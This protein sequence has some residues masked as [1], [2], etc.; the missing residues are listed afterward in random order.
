MTAAAASTS[1]SG[2]SPNLPG[3]GLAPLLTLRTIAPLPL[4]CIPHGVPSDDTPISSFKLA[5]LRIL[6][7]QTVASSSTKPLTFSEELKEKTINGWRMEMLMLEL[8]QAGGQQGA[9]KPTA[10]SEDDGVGQAEEPVI[11]FE[12]LDEHDCSLLEEG[13]EIVVRLKPGHQ[14]KDLQ[15]PDLGTRHR[16]SAPAGSLT[17]AGTLSAPPPYSV[18]TPTEPSSHSSSV[19]AQ[20]N[21]NYHQ[22]SYQD[23]RQGF[24]VVTANNVSSGRARRAPA[25]AANVAVAAAGYGLGSAG[26]GGGLNMVSSVA[27]KP[28][29]G[30]RKV[31]ASNK[32]DRSA[33]AGAAQAPKPVH[34]RLASSSAVVKADPTPPTSPL[35]PSSPNPA[36]QASHDATGPRPASGSRR[37]SSSV[38]TQTQQQQNG[39]ASSSSVAFGTGKAAGQMSMPLTALVIGPGVQGAVGRNANSAATPIGSSG[40]AAIQGEDFGNANA[41]VGFTAASGEVR[42]RPKRQMSRHKSEEGSDSI[43]GGGAG[44]EATHVTAVAKATAAGPSMKSPNPDR[45]AAADAAERRAAAAKVQAAGLATN[46]GESGSSG[47][48]AHTALSRPARDRQASGSSNRMQP[49]TKQPQPPSATSRPTRVELP[50]A[51]VLPPIQN[52]APFPSTPT[53]FLLE[54]RKE[55][56]LPPMPSAVGA[57]S[58]SAVSRNYINEASQLSGTGPQRPGQGGFLRR[59]SSKSQ[60]ASSPSAATPSATTPGTNDPTSPLREHIDGVALADEGALLGEA[61]GELTSSAKLT[62]AERRYAEIQQG[63]AKERE[64]QAE[65]ERLRREEYRAAD[66]KKAK[67]QERREIEA[68]QKAEERKWE[69]WEEKSDTAAEPALGSATGAAADVAPPRA[70]A[71]QRIVNGTVTDSTSAPASASAATPSRAVAATPSTAPR[72]PRRPA[73]SMSASTA[74][75]GKGDD[76]TGPRIELGLGRITALL[77]RLGSPHRGFPVIHVAGTN[78][79]GS[80]IA[81]LDAILRNALDIRTGT[82]VS[83]HLVERRDCCHVDGR[84]IARDVWRLAQADVLE[85]DQGLDLPASRRGPN[86]DGGPLKASP[87]ELLTA[88]MFQAFS[89]LDDQSRPEILLVEVGLGGRLDATNVFEPS[90]VLASVICPIARD[91][92]AF[93]GSDLVGI[94]REKAGIVKEGG[95]CI[96]ADQRGSV[97]AEDEADS[98]AAA[99]RESMDQTA[100]GP[101]SA[102]TAVLGPRVAGILDAIRSVCIDRNARFVKGCVPLSL[103]SPSSGAN[104]GKELDSTSKT[105]MTA[106]PSRPGAQITYRPTL[107]PTLSLSTS[108]FNPPRTFVA[109]P[110]DPPVQGMEMTVE[111]T[112]AGICASS[113]AMQT[114]WSIARDEPA[115]S[116]AGDRWEEVRTKIM[117]GLRD[118]EL[119]KVRVRGAVEGSRW[120]GRCEWIR[121]SASDASALPPSTADGSSTTIAAND[122]AKWI[123]MDGAHNAA[124]VLALRDYID[125]CL[126]LSASTHRITRMRWLVSFSQGKDYLDMLATLFSPAN[127]NGFNRASVARHEIGLVEFEPPEGMAWV[128][129]VTL[130]EGVVGEVGRTVQDAITGGAEVEVTPLQDMHEARRW[131]VHD[132]PLIDDTATMR[133]VTGSLYLVGHF[134]RDV[135]AGL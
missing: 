63:L 57:P 84:V 65:A 39:T 5:V 51:P 110:G 81:Y 134:I 125:D 117:W 1:A 132:A 73:V 54:E 102:E 94:A 104:A 88:Q 135:E 87:F 67:E 119:A 45:A 10:H 97:D 26:L 111:K 100:F 18:A 96:V 49:Q 25:Q 107:G 21:A 9:P 101:L 34:R 121:L 12:L 68:R 86:D 43:S 44:S 131:L 11:G 106:P 6:T 59:F 14:L 108:G 105:A 128:R 77:H 3:G 98:V 29:G 37:N 91:H 40:A 79:K 50:A 27:A 47:D 53:A 31:G 35:I 4:F 129:P 71:A 82:F 85:A 24:R 32:K 120:R 64:R 74:K 124:S 72:S 122:R 61:S 130:S 16:Y 114:L 7:G 116:V 33:S 52:L 80:T 109:H 48:T 133:V 17:R 113:L 56:D 19:A 126:S 112:R 99:R 118:D 23:Y 13:D 38:V 42:A 62:K 69:I 41:F 78:G 60:Q 55:R 92:E 46:N 90:Q 36:N 70:V 20:P 15:L 8:R 30:V 103:L 127:P 89:L 123:L 76:V 75:G 95:L 66:E 83:P 93:L 2:H 115:P 22:H 28:G 58:P